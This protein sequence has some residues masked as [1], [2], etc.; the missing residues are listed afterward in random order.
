[1]A[2]IALGVG[3]IILVS[4]ESRHPTAASAS[5]GLGTALASGVA[6]GLFY[7]SFA[8]TSTAAGMWPLVAARVVSVSLFG[9]WLLAKRGTLRMPRPA[10]LLAIGA[11]LLD[12]AA[13]ALYLI[14]ARI[15]P[16]SIVV[17]LSSLYPATTVLL[18]RTFLHERL[19]GW[20]ISGIACAVTA[21]LMIVS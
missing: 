14:A 10:L 11:G 2:G 16:L 8:K 12:M 17:T 1:M 5:A 9:G 6:I 18:A 13:N 4:R 3:S 15:G 19:N 7:L 20:Q 21:V